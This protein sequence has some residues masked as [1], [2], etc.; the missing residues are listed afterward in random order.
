[1]NLKELSQIKNKLKT[2][3]KNKNIIDIILFGSF[4]KGKVNPSDIDIAIISDKKID[5]NLPNFHITQITPTDFFRKPPTI[6]TILLKEGFS[7]RESK[8]F[9]EILR[10]NSK[11]M[12]VYNLS[13]LVS[14]KKVRIVNILRGKNK[15][16][17]MV[18]KENCVWISNNVF[19]TSLDK[20]YLFEQFFIHNSVQFKKMNL[21]IN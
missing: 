12:F 5:I 7:I 9:S 16:Q 18:E 8:P 11:I 17:G 14:S 21:L 20:E 1:M 3:L 4:A 10:Y 6:A 19:L 15:S 2:L 13:N